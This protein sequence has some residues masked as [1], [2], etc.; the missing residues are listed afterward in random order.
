MDYRYWKS[1]ES[2]MVYREYYGI[3][4]KRIGLNWVFV[5]DGTDL[6]SY[7]SN[8]EEITEDEVFLEII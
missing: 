1:K 5:T 2:G 3:L 8:L 6:Y 7:I 4:R